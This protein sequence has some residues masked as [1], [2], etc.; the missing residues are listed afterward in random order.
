M[1]DCVNVHRPG[2]TDDENAEILVEQLK[3]RHVQ[4]HFAV[5]IGLVTYE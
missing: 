1:R 3:S 4:D 2:Q 5:N